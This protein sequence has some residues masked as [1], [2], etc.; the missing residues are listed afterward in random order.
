[1]ERPDPWCVI[2]LHSN[3]Q[4]QVLNRFQR[5]QEAEAH[6]KVLQQMMPSASYT[7]MFDSGLESLDLDFDP[8]LYGL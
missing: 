7:L 6:L 2:C 1:M 3:L 4:H 5:R 8:S